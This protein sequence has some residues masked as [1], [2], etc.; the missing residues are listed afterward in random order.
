MRGTHR[1]ELNLSHPPL[2]GYGDLSTNQHE[3]LPIGICVIQYLSLYVTSWMILGPYSLE[4]E[5][6]TCRSHEPPTMC[7]FIM[8]CYFQCNIQI[9]RPSFCS[10]SGQVYGCCPQSTGEE[11]WLDLV[12][13]TICDCFGP[14]DSQSSEDHTVTYPDSP[15][16]Q[17]C[18]ARCQYC[19]GAT[20]SWWSPT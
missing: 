7:N 17:I 1:V 14:F 15:V 6:C 16:G 20:V 19:C 10:P 11:P 9:I 12:M 2:L 3:L 8:L 18:R 5:R 13:H 4:L